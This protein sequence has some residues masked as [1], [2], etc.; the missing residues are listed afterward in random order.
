MATFGGDPL[1]FLA[2]AQQVPWGKSELDYAGGLRGRPLEVHRRAADGPA[3]PGAGARSPSRARTRRPDE[4][5]RDE[6][7][8]GE[9]PGYYSGGTRGTGEPQPVIRIRRSTIATADLVNMAPMW[10]GAP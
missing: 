9:W 5:A 10:P 8:F 2:G 6:G 1:T 3:D 4:E 7:P